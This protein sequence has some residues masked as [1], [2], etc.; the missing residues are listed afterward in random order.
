MEA[1]ASLTNA[2]FLQDGGSGLWVNNYI[3]SNLSWPAQGLKLTLDS[4]FPDSGQSKLTFTLEQTRHLVVN[5]RIPYWAVKAVSLQLNGVELQVAKQPATFAVIDRQWQSGDVLTVDLPYSLYTESIPDK[6][7]YVGVKY[8]PHALV[9][10]GPASA[11]FAGTAA[12]LLAALTPVSSPPAC[13]FSATLQGPITPRTVIFKPISAVVDEYYNGYTLVTKPP[14][15]VQLD[16]VDIADAASEAAHGLQSANSATGSYAGVQWRD[17]SDNGFI[18]YTL[19]VSSSKQTMLACLYD[20]SD[21]DDDRPRLFDLQVL[22]A[23]GSYLTFATQSLDQEAPAMWYRVS[24]PIP[25][26][27][28]QG[29][30]SLT[31]RWQAKGFNG[32]AGSAGGLMD[33]V[34]TYYLADE[35]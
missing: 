8:G 13:C 7:E 5:V 23:D 34:Q 30:T 16:A 22:R 9:A 10:C 26:E 6:P 35:Q 31:F 32:K 4:S 17:A 18:S 11:T 27:L 24:Y 28:T 29:A 3:A 33:Q 21:G 25:L 14:A 1:F 12:E 20:G 2:A 19:Q 15:A